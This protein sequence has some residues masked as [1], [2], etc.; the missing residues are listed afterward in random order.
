M[1]NISTGTYTSYIFPKLGRQVIHGDAQRQQQA[2]APALA[3]ARA[4]HGPGPA[5]SC[6]SC[7]R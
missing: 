6:D 1:Y 4:G 3:A 5:R 2:E 7:F